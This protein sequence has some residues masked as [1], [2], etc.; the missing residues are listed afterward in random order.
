MK[1]ARILIAC[2]TFFL[3]QMIVAPKISFG[4]IGPDFTLLLVAYFAMNRPPVQGALAGFVIGLF[5][6]LFNPELLGLNALTK[7]VTGY[8]LGVAATKAEPDSTLFL[9][10]LLGAAALG[11]DIIYLLIFTGL[12]P[13]KFF[14]LLVTVSIPSAIYTALAGVVV[15]KFAAFL[16]TRVVR[17]LGKARS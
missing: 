7:S 4:D 1:T 12:N 16:G 8:G 9:A 10:A 15:H 13:V 17:T 2:F 14:I 6:D 3:L 11:H 5:Q